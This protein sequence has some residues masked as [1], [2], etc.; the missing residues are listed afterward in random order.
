[1]NPTIPN[2]ITLYYCAN[3]HCENS[4]GDTQL[5]DAK[6]LYRTLIEQEPAEFFCVN[7]LEYM[8]YQGSPELDMTLATYLE[9]TKESE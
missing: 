8:N 4:E 6:N 9:R 5:H 7:C 2:S 3:P 1:M